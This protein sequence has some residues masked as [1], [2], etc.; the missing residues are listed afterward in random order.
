MVPLSCLLISAVV[1]KHNMLSCG[2]STM[3]KSHSGTGDIEGGHNV[4][5]GELVEHSNPAEVFSV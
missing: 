1:L 3:P 5:N 2:S 4:V